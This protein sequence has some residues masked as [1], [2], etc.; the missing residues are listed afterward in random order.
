VAAFL[1][2]YARET[3]AIGV[4]LCFVLMIG[5]FSSWMY[6]TGPGSVLE[7]QITGIRPYF[8]QSGYGATQKLRLMADVRLASGRMLRVELDNGHKCRPRDYIQLR[9]FDHT[10]LAVTQSCKPTVISRR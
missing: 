1:A 3:F 9:E 10:V 6:P 2:H 7:G 5:L 4:V 8:P